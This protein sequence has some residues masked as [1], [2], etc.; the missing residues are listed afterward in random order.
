MLEITS[1]DIAALGDEDLRTLVA[2][3]CEAEVRRQGHAPSGVTWG[4]SQTAKDGGI[5][6]RVSLPPDPRISGF[7]PRPATGFQVKKLDMPR[8]AILDE[9][10]PDGV[11]REVIAQ[12]AAVGGA[13]VIVSGSG[14]TADSSLR[15]REKAMADG[16]RGLPNAANLTLAFYDRNRVASW[17]REHPALITWVRERVGRP[18]QGWR[19]LDRWS[20]LPEGTDPSYLVDD[21]A[22]VRTGAAD[23]GDGLSAV[24][25]IQRMREVLR[26]PGGV[27]RLVG[28]SGVG[29]TRLVEALFDDSVGSNS[30]DA[31]LA[32]YTDV[33]SDSPLPT[34][35]DMAKGLSAD[36]RRQVLVV[37]NCPPELHRRLSDIACAPGSTVSV[38]SIEYDIRE[39]QPEGTSVFVLDTASI[40]LIA[41]LVSRRF[42]ELSQ[43][44]AE[45]IAECSGG[46][47]RIALSLAG[48]VERS[49][50]VSQLSDAE[51]FRRLFHQRHVQDDS[52][53]L[54]AQACSLLYS[55]D[56][57]SLAGPYAEIPLL[58]SLVGR[59]PDDVFRA[60]AELQRRDLLQARGPW[61]AILPQ[62]IANRLAASA[63][64][65]FPR[66]KVLSAIEHGSVRVLRS[67]SRRLG[68]LDGS[69]NAKAI[70]RGWMA[71]GGLLA[72][73]RHLNA[74]GRAMLSNVAPTDPDA[75]LSAIEAAAKNLDAEAL[76]GLDFLL[77][78]L[79]AIAY[80]PSLF[81]RAT[82]MLVGVESLQPPSPVP[83][84]ERDVVSP[85]FHIYLSGTHAPLEMRLA[86]AGRLLTAQDGGT[87]QLAAGVIKALLQTNHFVGDD[88]FEFGARSRDYGYRP[89]TFEE[90]RD[91]FEKVLEFL[92][93]I[94]ES[95]S[96]RG[97][98]VRAAIAGMCHGLWEID[99]IE[100]TLDRLFRAV[101][102]KQFWA[103]GWLAVRRTL[104]RGDNRLSAATRERLVALE[105][106][107]RPSGLVEK[108]R[109][110]VLGSNGGGF[111]LDDLDDHG[112]GYAAAMARAS[113]M[114]EDLGREVATDKRAIAELL[115]DLTKGGNKLVAF[116]RGMAL[117][118][119]DPR[120]LWKALVERVDPK[121]PGLQVLGGFIEGLHD[122]DSGLVNDL[123][124][125]ALVHAGLGPWFP[126]LQAST[127]LDQR[128]LERLHHAIELGAAPIHTFTR[129]AWGRTSDGIPGPEFRRLVL[130]LAA[131]PGGPNVALEMV[132]MR[133]HSDRGDEK[134]I[135]PAV[136]SAGRSVLES[137]QFRRSETDHS[138]VDYKVA[139]VI[140]DCLGGED[141][142]P[143]VLA[144]CREFLRANDAHDLFAHE[145]GGVM[146]ALLTVHPTV[147]LD[148]L[149]GGDGPAR[150]R[151]SRMLNSMSRFRSDLMDEVPD[152]VF[153]TWCEAD[154]ATRF[155]VV[156]SIVP[157][158]KRPTERGPHEW[159]PLTKRLLT[160][161]PDPVRVL[162]ALVD[163]LNPTSW[164]GSL[165]AKLESRLDLL[166][167]LDVGS[168]SALSVAFEA[169]KA[170]LGQRIG[171]ERERERRE[172]GIRSQRF[173]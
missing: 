12:L 90:F 146:Q 122:R 86:V 133:L 92:T 73:L 143:V 40:P 10:M 58:A 1:T 20:R 78:L 144:M 168:Q 28:L 27:V 49:E 148:A 151:S 114:I 130:G 156:A 60:L 26:N 167:R 158:F 74:D 38:V 125:E 56:G 18:I 161:A 2:R 4:G 34:P 43:I 149:F 121:N 77:P 3:L 134:A 116:G 82:S 108:V 64:E 45:R 65:N 107:I 67:F 109:G 94:A 129:L 14:S 17:V 170:S 157:A 7:V 115:P 103:A 8:K 166:E 35:A 136:L 139:G 96:P 41:A 110:A 50:S 132:F 19:S 113:A 51:L 88:S 42:P 80:E 47:A 33:G 163:Q 173:E 25:G 172:D 145:Y 69:D 70:V 30:L 31:S 44:E 46:N 59:T 54:I 61:R 48:T 81:E 62:A 155:P 95:E 100:R 127:P 52:L 76:R 99:G 22:R 39:D 98:C 120:G 29:K 101:A 75:V 164:S 11:I 147:V 87:Q 68:L 154:P 118:A 140:R 131:R 165:A 138:D 6:V 123:L 85:L 84:Y 150:A 89:K 16:V 15:A 9:M 37:D 79:K 153:L 91:W 171:Q 128:A 152:A 160:Q 106:A 97:E 159:R 112:K 32:I 126:V 162:Q 36:G 21:K 83:G 124:D 57:E 105:Q 72:D 117:S 102:A 104:R 55:F 13:Y 119:P 135:D 141:G 5:D 111:D 169:A 23:E 142:L 93:P 137:I 71:P 53:H 66:D 24:D 63:L